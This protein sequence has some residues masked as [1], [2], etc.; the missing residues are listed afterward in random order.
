[1]RKSLIEASNMEK[2]KSVIGLEWY[3]LSNALVHDTNLTHGD[4]CWT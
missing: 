4:C 3:G 1:M 2:L